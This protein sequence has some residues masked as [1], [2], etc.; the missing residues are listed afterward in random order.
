MHNFIWL[1]LDC[2]ILLK[3]LVSSRYQFI[4]HSGFL[5]FLLHRC[6]GSHSHSGGLLSDRLCRFVHW[7]WK[8]S[9]WIRSRMVGRLAERM[10]RRVIMH[11]R[12]VLGL[13][14][15]HCRRAPDIWINLPRLNPYGSHVWRRKAPLSCVSYWDVR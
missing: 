3:M 11:W 10:W 6:C 14:A 12:H 5:L 15:M 9:V 7:R 8:I 2:C 1:L 4:I 13:P